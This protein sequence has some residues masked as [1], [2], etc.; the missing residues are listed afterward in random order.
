MRTACAAMTHAVPT[1]WVVLSSG[2]DP[3]DFPRAVEI[4]VGAGASGFLAGR[5]VWQSSIAAPD[6]EHALATDAVA[7]LQRLTDVVDRA[8]A[9]R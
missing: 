1:P 6:V 7:R 3:D 8:I 4:A 2:V 9:E 5:A